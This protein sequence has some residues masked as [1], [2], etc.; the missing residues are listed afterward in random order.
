MTAL[1]PDI[2]DNEAD[3]DDVMTRPTERLVSFIKSV[4]SPLVI[5]G[6]GGKMGPTLAV[7]AK[8]AA[9]A[10]NHPLDVIAVSRFSNHNAKPWLESR[11]V[12]TLSADLLQRREVEALPDTRDIIYLVGMKFGTSTNPSR[13][14]AINT[15]VPPLICERYQRSRIVALSTGNIYPLARVA[16]GGS[17][18]TDPLTPLGE[19]ANAAVAR[20][21]I[22]EHCS[23]RYGTQVAQL[24]LS[25]ALDLRYG[26]VADLA[27]RI[28][29]GEP[30]ELATGHFNG[31]WQGDA[32]DMILRSLD[33][34]ANPVAAF[35][36]SSVP[37][38]SVR[39]TALRLG[40]LLDRVPQ[41]VGTETGT[42]FVSNTGL[43][44][45]KLG[46]PTT[47]I[48][49]VLRWTANW[50]RCGGRSLNKPTHF[51]VRDGQF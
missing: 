33:L 15:L 40:E 38:Y 29:S 12:K 36:L 9:N 46:A 39:T 49:T 43:L 21:R 22:F 42:A 5:L 19:Y 18:E 27:R 2:I 1:L 11:G 25:Y 32:N 26:V 47:P 16:D 31:I 14:W 6:A 37:I 30:I 20:E 35:N 13:T 4:T 10:A 3:L 50:I 41:F 48:D 17:L 24:R 51:E 8:R 23:Q 44:T 28:W 7:L 45:S 34:T